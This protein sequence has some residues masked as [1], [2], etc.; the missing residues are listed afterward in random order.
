MTKIIAVVS[1]KGGAGKTSCA[2]HL[3]V[4]AQASGVSTA[5]FDLDEQQA[6][7]KWSD[8]RFAQTKN[9]QP[10]VH[11][12]IHS[13]LEQEIEKAQGTELIILDTAGFERKVADSAIKVADLA[14]VPVRPSIQDVQY[15]STTTDLIKYHQKPLLVVLNHIEPRL[16]ENDE[17][18]A[19]IAKLGLPVWSGQLSKAVN[20]QRP[21]IGGLRVSEFAVDCKASQEI[22]DLWEHLR[23][24]L[25]FASSKR[26]GKPKVKRIPR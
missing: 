24:R 18:R 22:L 2:I 1:L 20:Y 8:A 14:L 26:P 10:V 16:P 25:G 12:I 7:A 17:A 9:K 6:S 11:S 23:K 5:I 13:R 3:A 15:L 4:A 19:I 21:L